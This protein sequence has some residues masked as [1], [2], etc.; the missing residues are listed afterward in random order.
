MFLTRPGWLLKIEGAAGLILAILLYREM[1]ASWLLFALLFLAPDLSMIGY[2]G[3]PRIGAMTYNAAHTLVGPFA[4]AAVGVLADQETLTTLAVIWLAHIAMDRMAGYGL[5][6]PTG[7][8]D[9]HLD[10]ERISPAGPD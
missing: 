8:K 6:L 7:F 5:K 3:G 10:P 4:L 2:A 9:T 1:D